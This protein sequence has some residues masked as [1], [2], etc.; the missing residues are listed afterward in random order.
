MANSLLH[1]DPN[2][3]RVQL[4]PRDPQFF[5][6]RYP[7]YEELQQKAPIFYWAA[8]GF[9]CFVN[10]KDVAALFRDRRFGRQILHPTTPAEPKFKNAYHFHG[11]ESLQA[12]W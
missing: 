8:F 10:H 3:K 4:N 11:L 2:T 1:I 6:N 5:N 7:F 9:Y 12:T